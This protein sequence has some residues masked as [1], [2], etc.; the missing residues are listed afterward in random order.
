MSRLERIDF[1]HRKSFIELDAR[2]RAMALLD[3]GSDR[4][5]LGPFERI[6]SP[7]LAIQ[8]VTPQ[9]DDGC[10]EIKG[11]IDGAPAVRPVKLT[12]DSSCTRKLFQTG[13]WITLR[14]RLQQ[15]EVD[16]AL[17]CMKLSN[18]RQGRSHCHIS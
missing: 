18:S 15:I 14:S 2:A 1:V 5:L 6:E 9:S 8:G 16:Q 12:C 17:L 4:E 7:W 3:K 13:V 11:A 10:V